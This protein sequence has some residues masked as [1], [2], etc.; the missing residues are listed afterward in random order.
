MN[1]IYGKKGTGKTTDLIKICAKEGGYIVCHS[2]ME[3]S[4]VFKTA[5]ELGFKI[6]MPITFPE[7]MKGCFHKHKIYIDNID[8]C[9]SSFFRGVDIRAISVRKPDKTV[10]SMPENGCIDLDAAGCGDD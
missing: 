4:R 9:L 10:Y 2:F 5:Q 3:A 6:N 7:F 1:I 8:L